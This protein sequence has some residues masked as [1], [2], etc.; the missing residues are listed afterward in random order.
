MRYMPSYAS[1]PLKASQLLQTLGR[2]NQKLFLSYNVSQDEDEEGQGDQGA[3]AGGLKGAPEG[4]GEQ[5]EG[6]EQAGP[7]GQGEQG[8]SSACD[9][10]ASEQSL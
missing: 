4:Q 10:F 3:G 1:S 6:G 9:L 7:E 5:E 2:V 8:V